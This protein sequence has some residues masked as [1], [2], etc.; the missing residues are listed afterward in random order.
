M[1]FLDRI[2]DFFEFGRTHRDHG[3]CR[4]E[5]CGED[6]WREMTVWTTVGVLCS[7]LILS[8]DLL[9]TVGNTVRGYIS[10]PQMFLS[11]HFPVLNIS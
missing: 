7:R 10:I 4:G 1:R 11:S 9:A 3:V 2:Q 8:E 5:E 6:F